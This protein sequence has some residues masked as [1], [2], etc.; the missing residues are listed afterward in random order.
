MPE[1]EKK[2][3]ENVFT[4][5]EREIGARWRTEGTFVKSVEKEAPNGAFVF[6]DGPPFATG[7]PHYG[8]L[9]QSAIK[10]TIPR[11]KTMQGF[12]V[13]R[14]WGW[15]CHGLP[16][17]NQI[18]EKLGI[19]TKR[20]I[21]ALGVG[22]FN[23]AARNAVLEY[24]DIWKNVIDRLGRWVDMEDDYKTM[25]ATYT[26]SVWW[27]WKT[28]FD[29]GLAY[30]G[31]K[32]M[33][34]C[35][36][37]GTTLSNFEVNQG[38]K[39]IKDIAVTVKLPLLDEAGNVTN[40]SLLVW[41]TTPWTLP[42]NMAAAVHRDYDYVK[43]LDVYTAQFQEIDSDERPISRQY[44]ILAKELLKKNQEIHPGVF[45]F[46]ERELKVVEEMK[47]A[48]L[49]G[50]SYLPPFSYI[51]EKFVSGTITFA[52]RDGKTSKDKAWKIYHADYVTLDSGTGA[53][54]IAPAY[55][56][57]DLKLAEAEG[58]PVVHHV[59]HDGRF[60]AYVS[61]FAGLLV[62]PKDDEKTGTTHLEAD[63]AIVR[64]LA[65]ANVLFKKENITHSYPHCWRCDTPLI[66]YA[67]TSW[68]VAVTKIRDEVVAANNAVKWVPEH[69]GTSRFGKWL[70]GARDWAVS[71]QRYW[72]APLPVWKH[73]VTG[74]MHVFGSHKELTAHTKVSGNTYILMRH[75][76]AESNAKNMSSTKRDAKNPLTLR[77]QEQV[78]AAAKQFEGKKIDLI[79]ASP[80]ERTKA[81]AELVATQ[82][83]YDHT[84]IQFDD[85]LG[86]VQFGVL[87][88]ASMEEY[89][90]FLGVA[91]NWATK[92]PD[93]GESWNEVKRR[94]GN[95][96]YELERTQKGKTILIIAHNSPLRMMSA[97]AKGEALSHAFD[98][99]EDGKRFQN[100]E[101]RELTFVPIPHNETYELDYHRPYIDEYPVF[102][103]N[104]DRL[105]RVA[106]VFDCWYESGS[107]PFAQDHYPHGAGKLFDPA[108]GIGFPADFIAESVDQTRGWFYSMMILGVG[109]FGVS[110]YKHVI[111]NGLMLAE[112]GKKMSKKLK[113]YPDPVDMLDRYG[114]DT[115]RFYMLSSPIMKGEDLSFTEK[116][117]AE[118]LRKNL[119]RLDNVLSFYELFAG[120]TPHDDRAL[121][122]STNVLDQWMV[123]RLNELITEVT[124]GYEHYELD[125]ATK[126]ITDFIDDLSTWY[127][128]RSRDRVKSESD[129]DRAL[130]LGS[131]RAVLR[132]LA[133]VIAP[134]MPFYAEHLFARVKNAGDPE[135]VHLASWPIAGNI[136][137]E[138][139]EAMKEVRVIVTSALEQRVKE[140]IKVR[141][142]IAKLTASVSRPITDDSKKLIQDEVNVKQVEV[143][144]RE[145]SQNLSPNVTIVEPLYVE[146]EVILDT[147]MTPAL[148]QE[149]QARE[150]MRA[151]QDMRKDAG[152]LPSHRIAL[153][154]TTTDEGRAAIV[155][156]EKDIKRV[157]GVTA[158]VFD[159][160][161]G[162]KLSLDGIPYLVHIEK[163]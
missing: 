25:D 104:G 23:Y 127:V 27:S 116:H 16:L 118:L 51:K 130:A 113:N 33:H 39:D 144:I 134:V 76:E 94:T 66:N 138:L 109:L 7:L 149:G 122:T 115:L 30:E 151:L 117:V 92:S 43:A 126:P 4:R 18:E 10:D 133:L 34:L 97:A 84:A 15:D 89:H 98:D 110:P 6:Y 26:E 13:R 143:T 161:E 132:T 24:A 55:G 3:G 19:K 36:R 52:E 158:I 79:I 78:L 28:L 125:R 153:T 85:R 90:Q 57:E 160:N 135:S 48:A 87:D 53:V 88:G 72:G 47:G 11:Y 70:E 50:L 101:I 128:R 111:T 152:L 86:E 75:G 37:C 137:H 42:G 139:V 65:T 95:A 142:P 14:R 145:I 5:I 46:G 22:Q 129:A 81:T 31:F 59:D 123:S 45:Q 159:Q 156:F 80:F 146:P 68:F 56:D 64:H 103:E 106:D 71:R 83:G 9:L 67:T 155:A 17:E 2:E 44:V 29:K 99:D 8:H 163:V 141:Q 154:I 58:I 124:T 49:V 147:T 120:T 62:K 54:H 157:V 121:L 114:A 74:K 162:K 93:G 131:L 21:E 1:S 32:S 119:G 77:G 150:L 96:L 148:K 108:R 38:Y 63:I 91:S 40:T 61:D 112:D 100:A 12:S 73:P 60:M 35:P 82:I 107:M 136:D 102:D 140:N 41:T 69:I 105:V 20:E